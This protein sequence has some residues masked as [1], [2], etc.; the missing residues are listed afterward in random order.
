[1]KRLLLL[2]LFPVTAF[3]QKTEDLTRYVQPYSGTAAS[4]TKAALKHGSGTELNANTIPGVGIPFG[5]VQWTPQTQTG[6]AKCNPPYLYRDTK[7]NGF[8]GTHWLS[9]SCVPDYGSFTIMPVS[10]KLKTTAAAYAA[11]FSHQDEVTTPYYYSVTLPGYQLKTELTGT[12]RCGMMQFTMDK[13]D[14][15]YLLVVP[16]SDKSKGFVKIDK[17]RGEIVGYNPAYRI[18][19]GSGSPAGFNGWFVIQIDRVSSTG[20]V[21]SGK[22]ILL[23]DSILNQKESGAFLGFRLNKGERLRIRIG[24]SFSSLAG[25]R[26]NLQAEIKNWDFDELVKQQK[27]VWQKA[28]AQIKVKTSVEKDKR[29]FYTAF[30]H[31]LQHPRLFNDVDGT[32]PRFASQ[33]ELAKMAKGNYYDDFSMWDTYRAQLPLF[34]I[35]KPDLV[36]EFVSSM[37]IKGQQGGW[38]PIFPCWNNYTAAMIGDHVTPFIASAY[39]KGIRGYDINEAYRLMRQNAFELPPAADYQ[40]GKGRR[41][42]TSYLKYNYIPMED[43]VPFAFH[44]KE[45]VSRTLEYAYDDYALAMIAKALGK[46]EDYGKLIERAGNYKNVFDPSVNSVR[47]RNADGSWTA[48]FKADE[49]AP[50][51]TEGTPRQYSF[52][53]PQDIPGLANLMGGP[54][55]L[56]KAL[57]TLFEKNE[58]WHGNEPSH[59]IAFLY[60]YTASPWKTQRAVHQIIQDEYSDGP[61]G[62]SG[63]DD[64]GQMSA[65][66]VFASMGFYP[67]SPASDQYIICSPLFDGIEISLPQGKKLKITTVR[68]SLESIYI[69]EIKWN[70]K[71]YDKHYISH[72]M[73]VKGGDVEF[74]LFNSPGK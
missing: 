25:A 26:K 67:V 37:V 19:Q 68:T 33:Y 4:T 39:L 44:K 46:T 36:S 20:G 34:E 73:L 56:E 5:M 66:Y 65:W 58:Y 31:S 32:Y 7:I 35:L 49:K 62:L 16:N 72:D 30:Y 21:F 8:R 29:I 18:Y 9:G 57:D 64:S 22:D 74:Y 42:L 15:L 53:V 10:G 24:T 14:S 50:F 6:E 45:Q 12:A 43:D 61:G 23:Q 70:G 17:A 1:M 52:Y 3:A 59:H 48:N 63:N 13:T 38:M 60:N 28:L 54:A 47:G 69:K 27:A 41:A 55:G 40:N 71:V 11:E 2:L 51:I